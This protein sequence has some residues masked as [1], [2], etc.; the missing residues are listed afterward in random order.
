MFQNQ[1]YTGQIIDFVLHQLMLLVSYPEKFT[2]LVKHDTTFGRIFHYDTIEKLSDEEIRKFFIDS[3]EKVNMKC[4]DDALDIMVYFSNGLLLVMQQIG[5]SFFL[6][7][8]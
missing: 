6:V 1:C 2:A 3:F 4:T 8:Q 5:D 7:K